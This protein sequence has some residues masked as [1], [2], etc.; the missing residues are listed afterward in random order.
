MQAAV[1]PPI[2][3]P[4]SLILAKLHGWVNGFF[5]QLPNLVAALVFVVLAYWAGR[6]VA[7]GVR[8]LAQR[9]GR[10]DLGNILGS[11]GFAVIMLAAALVAAVIVFPGINPA[12][13]LATLGIGSVAV[14]FA[15]KDILQNLFAG[16]LLLI[17]RPFRRGDQIVVK[18]F[19]GT[20][21]HI[22]S[23]ATHIKTYDGRRVIIPNADIYTSPVTVNTA[24]PTRRD[25]FDIGIGYG[26]DPDRACRLFAEAVARMADVAPDPAPEV[27]PWGLDAS[28]VT[29]RARWWTGSKR[30]EIVHVKAAVIRALFDCAKANGI[31]LPY[32]TQTIL[33]HDQTEEAD[34]DRARQ[35]EGWPAPVS[36]DAARA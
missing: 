17:N 29:L 36:G 8:K 25:H 23:R 10:H 13:A 33:F 5:L 35:R 27:L 4:A 34:G 30:T 9:R 28:S 6:L 7:R 21:E 18:D 22:E 14:G 19:E 11:I 24:F 26:D 1:P 3:E 20:V 2:R 31:D 32:P 12:D 16:V 15:F